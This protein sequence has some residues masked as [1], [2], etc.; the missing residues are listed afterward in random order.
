[1]AT[2]GVSYVKLW[3]LLIDRKIKKPELKQAAKISPGTYAKLN[4]DQFVSMEV[5]G[6]ICSVLQCNVGD[7]M[8]FITQKED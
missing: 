2:I 6:R 4:K 3:K 8:D 7:V 5:M 1:M